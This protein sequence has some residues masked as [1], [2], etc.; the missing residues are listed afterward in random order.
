MISMAIHIV[1]GQ[2]KAGRLMSSGSQTFHSSI[3]PLLPMYQSLKV[4]VPGIE[5]NFQ[6]DQ[7]ANLQYHLE[8]KSSYIHPNLP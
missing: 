8:G 2:F 5:L 4:H 7:P 6:K 1:M 3:G